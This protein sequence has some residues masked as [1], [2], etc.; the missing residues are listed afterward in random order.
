MSK[1]VALPTASRLQSRRI[2]ALT[3]LVLFIALLLSVPELSWAQTGGLDK[4]KTTF[5]KLRDWLWVII[6]IICLCIGGVL[7]V[8]HSADIIRKDTLYQ[9]IGGV[10]FAGV[11]AGGIIELVF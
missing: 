4:T 9:W 10:I 7:G 1:S 11:A 6:P 8:L 3:A 5:E 2:I